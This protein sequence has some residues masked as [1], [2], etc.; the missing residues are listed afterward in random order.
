MATA[1]QPRP[2]RPSRTA[3]GTLDAARWARV[4]GAGSVQLDGATWAFDWWIGAE[5]RWHVP[6]DEAST[7]QRLVGAAPVVETRVRVPSGDAVQRVYGAR[8]ASGA[9]VVVVEVENQSK[10]PFAVAL[11]AR[12][13]EGTKGIREATA[14]GTELRVDGALALVAGRAPGRRAAAAGGVAEV[15][16]GGQAQPEAHVSARD[17][18]GRAEAA[19]VFPL[20]HTA[21]LRV[22]LP[23]E[24]GPI[25]VSALPSAAQVASGWRTHARRGV[26]IELPDRRLQEAYDANV[27][28]LLLRP[29]GFGVGAALS[30]AGF[31]PEA[32]AGLL[33]DPRALAGSANPGEALLALAAHWSLT[34]DEDFADRAVPL[35]ASLVA[36]LG[37]TGTPEELRLGAIAS[38]G[39]AGLLASAGQ[40]KGADDI[41]RAGEKMAAATTAPAPPPAPTGVEPL[42]G[43]L[44]K[45]SP[46]W[47]W[48]GP[49]DTHA[50]EVG[51]ALVVGVRLLLCTETTGAPAGLVLLPHPPQTWLGAGVE[52]HGMPTASGTLSYAVRWHGDRPALLWEL[53]PWPGSP[54]VRLT[55]G[56]DA[57]WSTTEASGEA[58]LAPVPVPAE[59][60]EHGSS[61]GGGVVTA[62]ELGRKPEAGSG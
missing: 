40:K 46:T 1:P 9:A 58:L 53:E 55:C 39:A 48:A 60:R 23:L 12:P 2:A 49:N 16:L 21:T 3:V 17:K 38:T 62:V 44:D 50:L 25:D 7:R 57:G 6:A 45:A 27:A 28:H 52:V 8:D 47:T 31:A 41:R 30:R 15:V 51:A 18:G 4:D 35:V 59:Q 33:S 36:K 22:V 61:G 37:R 14:E 5:D 56:L 11:A 29:H 10:V 34:H 26:R 20:A 42:L 13:A 32:A 54:P 19:L 24:G 43:L